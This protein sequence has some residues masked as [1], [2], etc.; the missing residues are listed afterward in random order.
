MDDIAKLGFE[1][2]NSPLLNAAK[3]STTAAA[4]IGKVGDAA[5]AAS[6]KVTGAGRSAQA[7]AGAIGAVGNASVAA[8]PKVQAAGK[9]QDA[10]AQAMGKTTTAASGG[11]SAMA[12]ASAAAE[13]LGRS[14]QAAA[15]SSASITDGLQRVSQTGLSVTR[16]ISGLAGVFGATSGSAAGGAL[17]AAM[18]SSGQILQTLTGLLGRFGAVAGPVIG[19]LS[20]LGAGYVAVS[21]ALAPL[22]DRFARY[23]AQLRQLTGSQSAAVTVM[24]QLKRSSN[25]TGNSLD[26]TLQAYTRMARNSED[27][28]ATSKEILQLTETIQMLGVVSNAGAGEMASG[29]LQ[30]SQA[31]ASGRLN[32]DELRSIMEN[33][34]AL[35]KAIADGLGVSVGQLRAM[36]AAGE[37][38]GDKVFRALLSRTEQVRREFEQLPQTTEQAFTR[39]TNQAQ[40]FGANLGKALNSSETVQ[41]LLNALSAALAWANRQ[42]AGPSLDEQLA[43]VSRR[44]EDERRVAGT[45]N[46]PPQA[47]QSL[48][49]EQEALQEQLRLRMRLANMQDQR[50]G[51]NAVTAEVG[52][53]MN[54]AKEIDNQTQS[55]TKLREQV[56]QLEKSLA[57][58]HQQQRDGSVTGSAYQKQ[59]ETLSRSLGI[60]KAQLAGVKDAADQLRQSFDDA[61]RAATM[62]RGGGGT[63]MAQ[64]AI[65]IAR[66]AATQGRQ[67]SAQDI[68][69][70]M[71]DNAA[72]RSKDQI[73][74][75][76]RQIAQQRSRLGVASAGRNLRDQVDVAIEA[77]N[78]RIATFGDLSDKE[79][80]KA[81][82]AVRE[83]G[84]AL[85]RLRKAQ[86]EVSDA[87][88]VRGVQDQIDVFEAGNRVL[89]QG[90]FA[91]RRAEAEERARQADRNRPGVGAIQLQQFDMQEGRSFE[92]RMQG[93]REQRSL[94]EAMAVTP[95]YRDRRN[96]EL[97]A[98]IRQAQR[99]VSPD[100]A[101]EIE[102]QMRAIEFA[103]IL[104][105]DAEAVQGVN[106][107]TAI[108]S[109]GLQAVLG[110]GSSFE[111]RRAQAEARA[112]QAE[113]R[114]LGMSQALEQQFM[115]EERLSTEQMLSDASLRTRTT[116]E[117]E[118]GIR[119][120]QP[121]RL[122]A[123][124][125]RIRAAQENAMPVFAERIDQS[126]R[127]EDEA[128]LSVQ[129]AEQA[130]SMREQL[131]LQQDQM[132][133]VGKEGDELS[134]QQA[135]MAKRNELLR[136][137]VA[138]NSASGREQLRLTEEVA[139]GNVRLTKAQ[140]DAK[141]WQAIWD[142]AGQGVSNSLSNAFLAAFDKSKK[143]GDVLRQG[144]SDTFKKMS[145][146]ILAQALKPLQ[147]ALINIAKTI[148]ASIVSSIAGPS[149][150]LA[151]Y[152]GA[153]NG[154]YFAGGRASFAYG[155]VVN[156]PTMFRFA[157]GGVMRPGIMGEAGPEAIMPLRRGPD[158]R[159]GVSAAGAGGGGG[160]T[161]NISVSVD[162]SGRSSSQEAQGGDA[163]DNRGQRLGEVVASAVRAEIIQQQ[164][165]G[166]LLARR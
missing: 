13:A 153:A 34:P 100:R 160:S 139:R 46:R 55:R 95:G 16:Q 111:I 143:A 141:E 33:M 71:V 101:S 79:F 85:L 30:L 40:E 123:L 7:A 63:Q 159:L 97:E 15:R 69:R 164:R 105:A 154:A 19:T 116:R 106:E 8:A 117:T 91:V 43:D 3:V 48:L 121:R 112:R 62:G 45:F 70:Q 37:L 118:V 44:I 140:Q 166:G 1:I 84:N 36:G 25:Q 155:G 142:S 77:E 158:G 50:E 42:V 136:E 165:P 35:A 131:K 74:S 54:I 113:E 137:G 20:T 93:M 49:A 156:S 76:E 145:A 21:A 128:Q 103:R 119:Q 41:K 31:L 109:V 148:G 149:V 4:Q 73:G 98:S 89:A 80:P 6:K 107:S 115:T 122:T 14:S 163:A 152:P 132:L 68:F 134:V 75:I 124:N 94:D 51:Q 114:N 151:A 161:Y 58:L 162:A 27:I 82:E 146:D 67:V 23:E 99:G 133:L 110:G 120:G 57:A 26:T 61:S 92:Q 81:A 53:G 22:Q 102:R 2:D 125:Q 56:Q 72:T 52:R 130:E 138:L 38:T 65:Q 66:Q 129:L 39:M 96:L 24:E 47:L 17:N 10:L 86:N 150:P 12:K 144:L 88:F 78:W 126:M 60:A 127:A 32:G 90:D 18:A 108:T 11:T 5:D 87:Q 147:D 64:E 104:R 9:A 28:G 29:M 135:L 83:Y 157:Q 59:F